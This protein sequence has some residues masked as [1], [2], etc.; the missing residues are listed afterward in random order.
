[1]YTEAHE[2]IR[3]D[4]AAKPVEKKALPAKPYRRSVALN[5]KQRLAKV[6]DAKAIFEAS[7]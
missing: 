6:A 5:K 7:K 3:A 2:A 1:M 4:P